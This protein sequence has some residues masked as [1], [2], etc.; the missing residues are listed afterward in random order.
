[1]FDVAAAVGKLLDLIGLPLTNRNHAAG[2]G[3]DHAR[4]KKRT[5]ILDNIAA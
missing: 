3:I 5:I 2:G 4:I 1:M